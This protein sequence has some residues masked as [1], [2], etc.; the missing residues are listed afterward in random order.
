MRHAVKARCYAFAIVAGF[1]GA[2]ASAKAEEHTPEAFCRDFPSEQRVDCQAAAE[3]FIN[4]ISPPDVDLTIKVTVED[5]KLAY[6][7]DPVVIANT[8]ADFRECTATDAL[9]V[10]VGRSVRLSLIS[11]DL[12]IYAWRIPSWD[13]SEDFVPGRVNEAMIEP[14]AATGETE[15]WLVDAN[16]GSRT[17]TKV[18]VVEDAYDANGKLKSGALCKS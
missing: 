8:S 4:A 15:G 17:L 11:Y 14:I 12:M 6:L 3:V 5:G 18:R 16:T 1:A 7:Y 2:M 9:V 13:L 10:P